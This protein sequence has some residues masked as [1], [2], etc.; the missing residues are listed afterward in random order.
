M[1]RVRGAP[2]GDLVSLF[3]ASDRPF[4]GTV[5]GVGAVSLRPHETLYPPPALIRRK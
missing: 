1:Q 5:P 2:G 3:N 4:E